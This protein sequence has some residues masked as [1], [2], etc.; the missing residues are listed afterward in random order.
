[1]IP[2]W[3]LKLV[4]QKLSKQILCAFMGQKWLKISQTFK[5]IPNH[6]VVK[7]RIGSQN[8]LKL[9]GKHKH[10]QFKNNQLIVL[11]KSAIFTPNTLCTYRIKLMQNFH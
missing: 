3:T 2:K 8:T 7:N 10:F 5:V 6:I 11:Q 1:M 9:A 4:V